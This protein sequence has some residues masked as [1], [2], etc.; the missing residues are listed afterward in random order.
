MTSDIKDAAIPS[1]R[2]AKV[3]PIVAAA[4]RVG[5]ITEMGAGIWASY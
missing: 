1:Y 3:G 4:V 2:Q 5:I